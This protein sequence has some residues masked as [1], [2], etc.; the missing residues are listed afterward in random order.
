MQVC[1]IDAGTNFSAVAGLANG[2]QMNSKRMAMS[3]RHLHNQDGDNDDNC[4]Y[5]IVKFLCVIWG[6]ESVQLKEKIIN[7]CHPFFIPDIKHVFCHL[8]LRWLSVKFWYKYLCCWTISLMQA[9][10]EIEDSWRTFWVK[11]F[12]KIT[13]RILYSCLF[14]L[15]F[16]LVGCHSDD[17]QQDTKNICRKMLW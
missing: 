1:S 3:A 5:L 2:H 13:S 15:S 9:H 17:S 8:M 6:E 14:F 10:L 11:S 4:F 12:W 16:S 7:R